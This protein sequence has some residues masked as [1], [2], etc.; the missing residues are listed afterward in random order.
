MS[1]HL[2]LE[3]KD[4]QVWY[5]TFDG[6]SKVLEGINLYCI[7]LKAAASIPAVRKLRKDADGKCR[8]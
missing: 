6:Y 1:D 2:L 5:Q 8:L 4:L 3:I 7:P